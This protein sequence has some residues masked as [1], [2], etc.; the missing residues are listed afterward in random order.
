MADV[1][2]LNVLYDITGVNCAAHTLQLAIKDALK[3]LPI[4]H[5]NI[6]GLCRNVAKQLR[7]KSSQAI[8]KSE[9]HS[10]NYKIPRIDVA[11]RWGYTY[12]MVS[13][14]FLLDGNLFLLLI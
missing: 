3:R 12:L 7:R 11:T 6:I 13:F 8:Y 9:N 14:L 10:E 2:G 5:E 4:Q 1:F